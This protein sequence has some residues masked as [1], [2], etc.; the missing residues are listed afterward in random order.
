MCAAITALGATGGFDAAIDGP[1]A[2][3]LRHEAALISAEL[4][5]A[6]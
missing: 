5:Y 2:T 6:A 1:V 3:A 4:G